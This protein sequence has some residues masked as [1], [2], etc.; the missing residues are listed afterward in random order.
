[1]PQEKIVYQSGEMD[2]YQL[3]AASSVE[4]D[5]ASNPIDGCRYIYANSSESTGQLNP[6]FKAIGNEIRR[7]TSLIWQQQYHLG[8]QRVVTRVK[9]PPI[10]RRDFLKK[11]GIAAAGLALAA[12]APATATVSPPSEFIPPPTPTPVPEFYPQSITDAEYNKLTAHEKVVKLWQGHIPDGWNRFDSFDPQQREQ[13]IKLIEQEYR[14]VVL[15]QLCNQLGYVIDDINPHLYSAH[16]N[17]EAIHIMM[18]HGEGREEAEE[19]ASSDDGVTNALFDKEKNQFKQKFSLVNT[20]SIFRHL[21]DMVA[22]LRTT[23][24]QQKEFQENGYLN[25]NIARRIVDI[26]THESIHFIMDRCEAIND[27][28]DRI[29]QGLYKRKLLNKSGQ[30]SKLGKFL[31]RKGI[32]LRGFNADDQEEFTLKRDT[33]E[34]FRAY[35][36]WYFIEQ[37]RGNRDALSEI[38]IYTLTWPYTAGIFILK[39][40]NDEL[41]ITPKEFIKAYKEERYLSFY[42]FCQQKGQKKNY[43]LSYEDIDSIWNIL[44]NAQGAVFD[45]FGLV[46]DYTKAQLEVVDKYWNAIGRELQKKKKR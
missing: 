21:H 31:Y 37:M 10:T 26:A 4:L 34:S 11:A 35:T 39:K 45:E 43:D 2:T 24:P 8:E 12:C 36:Q 23:Y 17:D 14:T 6:G 7:V 22:G 13:L 18:D 15:P 46:D 41:G 16:S 5:P 19:L 32:T 20:D 40:L 30:P 25:S 1:M 33:I 27:D 3:T 9:F 42:E 28:E 38:D 29:F 44:N